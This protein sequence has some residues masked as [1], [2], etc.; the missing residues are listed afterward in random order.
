MRSDEEL[1]AFLRDEIAPR[2]AHWNAQL[3]PREPW[4]RGPGEIALVVA[5]FGVAVLLRSATP[6]GL[7]L[8]VVGGRLL[9]AAGRRARVLAAMRQDVLGRVVAFLAPGL[10]YAA[11]GAIPAE[12]VRRSGLFR[13]GFDHCSG[14]DL[15]EGRVGATALRFSE[16]RLSRRRGKKKPPET[17][18]RGLFLVADFPKAFAG[19]VLLLPD[20]AERALG[21]FGRAL[22]RVAPVEGLA[23]VELEDPDFE[24][25]FACYGSDPVETRYLLSPSLIQRLLRVRENAGVPL[26]LALAEGSLLLALPHE[27]DLFAASPGAGGFDEAALRRWAGE[28]GFATGLVEELDL[29]TRIWSKPPPRAAA[30]GA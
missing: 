30:A 11:R 23:L 14:E 9:R 13:E 24:R 7:P 16:I 10:R 1:R 12:V 27:A 5:A 29:D 3:P 4:L 6:L 21:S 19:R 26:R 18:F 28:L 22:Q 20:R 17:V 15:F 8:L 2:V 25:H